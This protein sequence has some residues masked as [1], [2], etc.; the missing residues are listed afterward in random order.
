MVKPRAL[1]P[2]DTVG[3]IAPSSYIFDLWDLGS[4]KKALFTPEP[5]GM[6]DN[7]PESDPL[8]PDFPRHTV[9]PGRARGQTVGGN[10]TLISTTMGTPYEIDTR[11]KILLLED[12]GEAPYRIDRMLVQLKL[13]GKLADAAG[14][15]WGTCTDCAP[16]RSSFEINL[17]LSELLD[18][19]LGSLGR[20]V[21]AGLVF[22]HTKE[23]ATIPL[24]VEAELD[25]TGKTFAI[26]ERATSPA[27]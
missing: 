4:F 2:G 12:T 20:P 24:G 7:P 18:D 8:S 1:R 21:L 14:I 27:S 9:A 19:L 15:V 5:I 25:A 26:V 13:A 23:K 16:L 17:S 3:L 6:I 10:L 22:G 11:G